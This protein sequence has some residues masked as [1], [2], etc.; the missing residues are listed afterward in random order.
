MTK[1][2]EKEFRL[3]T[4]EKEFLQKI[5]IV[6]KVL[7][8]KQKSELND[9]E[10]AVI[11]IIQKLEKEQIQLSKSIRKTVAKAI[12]PHHIADW[13]MRDILEDYNHL[14][15]DSVFKG[16]GNTEAIMGLA[17]NNK[18]GKT[19]Q[20]NKECNNPIAIVSYKNNPLGYLLGL[21]D[22]ISQAGREAPE[23]SK[24][25][26]KLGI[27]YT[28]IEKL[29]NDNQTGSLNIKIHYKDEKKKEEEK[30]RDVIKYYTSPALFLGLENIHGSSMEESLMLEIGKEEYYFF[31]EQMD[32]E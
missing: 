31:N 20:N 16:C 14:N 15:D 7:S 1:E 6:K 21:C 17:K 11:E 24:F 3:S 2:F 19:C 9:C 18:S 23:L 30:E 4:N 27:T 32:Q 28:S 10:K 25:T 5:A 12:M 8:R 22:I 29:T 26:K 13:G